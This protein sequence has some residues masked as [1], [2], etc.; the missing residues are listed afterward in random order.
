MDRAT[1]EKMLAQGN[2]NLLLRYTL[3]SLCFKEGM[4]ETAVE[5]LQQ[6]VF[7]DP[8]HSASWKIYGKA[9]A[10]LGRINDAI[11]AYEQ[12]IA[13]ANQKGDIQAVK[14]MRVFLNRLKNQ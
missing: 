8:G 3:G 13:V 4:Y 7:Q 12:G 9:L 14:E 10:K 1:L 2:D 6:A 11:N 5:H